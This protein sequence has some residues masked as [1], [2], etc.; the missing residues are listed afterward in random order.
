MLSSIIDPSDPESTHGQALHETPPPR[1]GPLSAAGTRTPRRPA[2]R[3]G[4]AAVAHSGA[5]DDGAHGGAYR[6]RG[7][8]ER[9]A[10]STHHPGNAGEPRDRSARRLRPVADRQA[11]RSDDRRAHHDD[12]GRSSG[13]GPVDQAGGRTRPLPRLPAVTNSRLRGSRGAPTNWRPAA[14]AGG[15]RPRP[16]P[17]RRRPSHSRT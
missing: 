5:A 4:G 8:A 1:G 2:P 11:Q 3:N 7:G 10:H 14:R 16:P 15:P 17:S 13:D 6:A 9:A 12:G